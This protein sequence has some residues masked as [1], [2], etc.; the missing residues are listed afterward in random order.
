[1]K[2]QMTALHHEWV[3]KM[4]AV[5]NDEL[6]KWQ[7]YTLRS[8][9][10]GYFTQWMTWQNDCF[11]HWGVKKWLNFTIMNWQMTALHNEW[12]NKMTALHKDKLTQCLLYMI[13]DLIK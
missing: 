10:N 9:Q 13:N 5:H 11:T 2:Q 3:V 12:V 1:M 8:W 7:H 4:T 6:T